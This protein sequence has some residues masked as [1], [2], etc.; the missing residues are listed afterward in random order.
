MYSPTSTLK[1]TKLESSNLA[2]WLNVKSLQI[3]DQK[4]YFYVYANVLI[5]QF[6]PGEF[7]GGRKFFPLQLSQNLLHCILS[8]R[9][10]IVSNSSQITEGLISYIGRWLSYSFSTTA[11]VKWSSQGWLQFLST[12]YNC[13]TYKKKC[14]HIGN[15]VMKNP[16]ISGKK[17]M[18]SHV[19]SFQNGNRIEPTHSSLS[20]WQ[21]SQAS[22]LILLMAFWLRWSCCSISKP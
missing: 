11:T 13:L 22:G 3:Q 8:Y 7:K 5:T 2:K 15:F 4:K 21:N 20:F 6:N 19:P 12:K 10:C 14:S 9:L 18:L 1:P 17:L 16:Q